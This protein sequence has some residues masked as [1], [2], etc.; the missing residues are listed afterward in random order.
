MSL[1]LSFLIASIML[2]I[3]GFVVAVLARLSV[4]K[5]ILGEDIRTSNCRTRF[6]STYIY[7]R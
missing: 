2:M 6:Y 5:K 7:N 3:T 4:K 1:P